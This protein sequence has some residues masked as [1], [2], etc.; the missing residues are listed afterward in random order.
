MLIKNKT[1]LNNE[2]E[3]LLSLNLQSGIWDAPA[4]WLETNGLGGWSGASVTGCNTR[5]YHGLLVAATRPPAER[6]NLLSKLD[7]TIIVKDKKYELGVNQYEENTIHPNGYQYLQSFAKDLFPEWVYEVEGIQLKKTI[8]MVHDENTT[9]IIYDILKANTP[10]TLE[11]LPLISARGYHSLQHSYNNIWRD[12][13]F[14]NGIFRNRPFESAPNIFISVPGSHYEHH[15][16]WFYKFNYAVEIYRGQDFEEDLFNH[17]TISTELKEGDSIGIIISTENPLGR[18]ALQ[19]VQ[20]EKARRQSLIHQL[21][22]E[23]IQQLTLAADQFIVKRGKDLKTVIAGYH[24]FT[25]WGRDTM[26]SLPG[27]CLST[28]RYEV[29]KKSY[30]YLRRM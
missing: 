19:L 1:E 13:Q 28:E 16:S 6:M 17:G 9:I 11:L 14:E 23:T 20:K 25:D 24:W 2:A 18:D 12:V 26:I 7:E 3:K 15:P 27:L 10:F 30:L 8:A 29:Q 4:E 22:N 21:D 5:R